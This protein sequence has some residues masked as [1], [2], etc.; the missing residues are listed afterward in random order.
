MATFTV[1]TTGI[2]PNAAGNPADCHQVDTV[3]LRRYF[4]PDAEVAIIGLTPEAAYQLAADLLYQA[5][6]GGVI[7]GWNV[8]FPEGG[9]SC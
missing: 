4:Q 6:D 1:S 2:A 9:G 5:V 3:E 8:S 7:S